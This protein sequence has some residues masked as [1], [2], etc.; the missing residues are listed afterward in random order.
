[1][2]LR[3]VPATLT[4]QSAFGYAIVVKAILRLSGDF[5]GSWASGGTS[6]RKPEPSPFTTQSAEPVWSSMNCSKTI[7]PCGGDALDGWA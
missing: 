6:R 3:P 1:M 4:M 7:L 2:H 5:E